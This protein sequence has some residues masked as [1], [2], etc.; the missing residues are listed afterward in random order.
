MIQLLADFHP[1]IND[2]L[3]YSEAL[4]V[5]SR[6]VPTTGPYALVFSHGSEHMLTTSAKCEAGT[7][8]PP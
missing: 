1:I 6:I 2:A 4:T 3:D 7:A 8:Y 5:S